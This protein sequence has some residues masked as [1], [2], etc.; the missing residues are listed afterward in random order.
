[1]YD[2]KLDLFLQVARLGSFS[3]ASKESFITTAAVFKQMNQLE[4]ECGV[5]LFVRSK[6]GVRLTRA[7]DSLREDAEEIIKRSDQ[8]ILRAQ[9]IEANQSRKPVVYDEIRLGSSLMYPYKPLMQRINRHLDEL[10]H[11]SSLQ[12]K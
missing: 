1:M 10:Q 3:I 2:K 11:L 5:K 8:A 4:Q 9:H 6:R 7:G 12:C